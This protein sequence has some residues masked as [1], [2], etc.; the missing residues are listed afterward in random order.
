MLFDHCAECRLCCHIEEGYPPL[1]VSLTSSEKKQRKSIC[2]ETKCPHLSDTGCVLG[3]EKPFSCKLYPLAYNP[4]ESRFYYDSECPLMPEYI[5]QLGEVQSDASKH[6]SQM[7]AEIERLENSDLGFLKQNF[8]VDQN[9]FQLQTL[10]VKTP[11]P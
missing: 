4:R 1:E 7:R 9:Y 6:L 8:A 5:E 2:I 10:P 11:R 3:D